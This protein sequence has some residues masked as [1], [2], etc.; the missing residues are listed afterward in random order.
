MKKVLY[1]ILHGSIYKDRYHNI[2]DTW[3]KSK[4]CLFYSDYED[5]DKNIVKVSDRTDY[6][7]NEEKHIN[8]LH[9][10]SKN[11]KD[12]EWFFFCDDDTFVNTK[13]LESLLD[14]LDKKSV[15]GS[16]LEGTWSIDPTLNYCS[17]GAGYLIN[18]SLLSEIIE[19]VKVLNSG[20]SDVTLGLI[21]RDLGVKSINYDFFKSQPPHHYGISMYE[22]H[23]YITFHYIKDMGEMGALNQIISNN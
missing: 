16:L 5:L 15:H 21:L 10:V 8:S 14:T 6:H 9:Y 7:S 1:V 17:G 23:N 12:Y 11:M 2:K 13:K 19:K 4:D 3:G 22:T 18:S 20:F